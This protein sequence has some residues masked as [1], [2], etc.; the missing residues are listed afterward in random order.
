M[1]VS[2]STPSAPPPPGAPGRRCQTENCQTR[3]SVYNPGNHCSIHEKPRFQRLR[4]EPLLPADRCGQFPQ[5]GFEPSDK[6]S[7]SHRRAG[8]PACALA[9]ISASYARW[10]KTRTGGVQTTPDEFLNWYAKHGHSDDAYEAGIT[11]VPS[12][13]GRRTPPGGDHQCETF[14]L[15]PSTRHVA[16]HYGRG[17]PTCVSAR[18]NR[19]FY[20]WIRAGKGTADDVED[21]LADYEHYRRK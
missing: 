12:G 2:L 9:R 11:D 21:F 5:Y 8:T 6:H 18:R 10:K 13:R 17:T 1:V 19:A 15:E 4:G 20:E 7:Q 3:L 16:W 14:P